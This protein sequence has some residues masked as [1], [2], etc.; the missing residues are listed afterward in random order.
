[1]RLPLT[2]SLAL[3]TMATLRAEAPSVSGTLPEDYIPQLRPLLQ[4]AVERSPTQVSASIS[5]AQQEAAK[6]GSYAI[7]WPSVSVNSSYQ[8]TRQSESSSKYVS[9]SQG[10]V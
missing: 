5:V 2:L 3:A 6:I 4:M 7:L 8:G 9:T 10:L 1:M